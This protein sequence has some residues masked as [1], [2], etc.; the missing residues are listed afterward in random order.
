MRLKAIAMPSTSGVSKTLPSRSSHQW[1]NRLFES[2]TAVARQSGAVTTQ[3]P[4]I[5]VRTIIRNA[6]YSTSISN[7]MPARTTATMSLLASASTAYTWVNQPSPGRKPLTRDVFRM[8][9]TTAPAIAI[10][11]LIAQTIAE[12]PRLTEVPGTPISATAT[13]NRGS[14]ERMVSIVPV[15]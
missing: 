15:R 13:R 8:S 9:P 4:S 6:A 14:T 5:T 1:K 10:D 2:N 7:G 3:K 11:A 12:Y